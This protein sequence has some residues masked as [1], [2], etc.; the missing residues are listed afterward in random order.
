MQT[1]LEG[2]IKMQTPPD[3][4]SPTSVIPLDSATTR[5]NPTMTSEKHE[6][7][8]DDQNAI[9]PGNKKR[10]RGIYKQNPDLYK[11]MS[12]DE[13]NKNFL[14]P[15]QDHGYP[16]GL[17][18]YNTETDGTASST[19]TKEPTAKKVRSNDSIVD[20]DL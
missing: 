8:K 1:P 20:A 11:Y 18:L 14:D 16:P 15:A 19:Q 3:R 7:Q 2:A 10:K 6:I 13:Y 5:K 17:P 4:K 12:W 9:K